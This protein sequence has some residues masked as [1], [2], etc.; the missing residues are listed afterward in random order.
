MSTQDPF[1]AIGKALA[2]D[3]ALSRAIS[4]ELRIDLASQR[5]ADRFADAWDVGNSQGRRA[6][7]GVQPQGP[8]TQVIVFGPGRGVRR[9]GPPPPLPAPVHR[10][11]RG[12]WRPGTLSR[13]Q[14]REHGTALRA[15]TA[16]QLGRF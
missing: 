8:V 11:P 3:P 16:T 7:P 6:T 1:D 14:F 2:A 12:Q 13:D 15:R 9:G 5:L 4:T 10:G